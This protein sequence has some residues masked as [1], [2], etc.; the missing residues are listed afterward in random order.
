[1]EPEYPENKTLQAKP[2]EDYFSLSLFV[3]PSVNRVFYQVLMNETW[4]RTSL[5]V[6]ATIEMFTDAERTSLSTEKFFLKNTV[7]EFCFTL[8]SFWTW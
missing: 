4:K 8:K 2:K 5:L 3:Y 1:M 6:F 7:A